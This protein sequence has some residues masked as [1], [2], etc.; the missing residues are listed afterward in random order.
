MFPPQLT[1][2]LKPHLGVEASPHLGLFA[3]LPSPDHFLPVGIPLERGD[4]RRGELRC[5]ERWSQRFGLGNTND[6]GGPRQQQG[7]LGVMGKKKES[8]KEFVEDHPVLLMR[9]KEKRGLQQRLK[10][11]KERKRKMKRWFWGWR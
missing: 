3:F 10:W 6:L 5:Q 9:E 11:W 7:M 8:K 4:S 2:A 1:P